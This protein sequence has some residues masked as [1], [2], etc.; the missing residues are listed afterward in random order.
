[1][2]TNDS[3]PDGDTLTV[4]S[5][6]S[7]NG[8]IVIE[9]DG[10][11]TYQPDPNFTGT[12][13]IVY[14]ISDGNGGT[15]TATVDVTVTAVNDAPETV[16]LPDLFDSN[17]EVISV[18]LGSAFSDVDDA[19]LTYTITGLPTGLTFDPA[20]GEVTGTTGATASSDVPDGEYTVTVTA[21]DAAGLNASTT[22]TW[23]ITNEPPRAIND[24][25]VGTEDTLINL[26]VLTNDVDPDGDP[27]T[28]IEI[29]SAVATNGTA[30]ILADGTIDFTPDPD[31]NGT[32]TVTYTIQD[33]NGKF[34]SAVA[35]I[36]IDAV[37]DAPDG[38]IL[39]DRD[40]EDG[41]VVSV[42][43]GA[44]FSDPEGDP[45]TF[46]TANLP[47]GLSIDMMT[48][49]ITGTIDPDASQVNG[50]VYQ[51]EVT[52]TD[53]GGE[54]TTQS[55]IWTI[56]NPGPTAN[57]DTASTTEDTPTAPIDVLTNDN[58]PDGDAL[59]VT[60]ASAPNGTVVINADGTLTYTPDV[61]FNGTD[62]I[63][64]EIS[65]GQ[66]GSSTSTVTVTVGAEMMIR[67]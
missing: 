27:M 12:D 56:T 61:N 55:F 43:F 67:L 7:D 47:A 20:T 39:P 46:T 4:I 23:T 44:L 50:G 66:G 51:V 45:L 22:F 17:N 57:S 1:M 38:T 33:A 52:A 53:D 6:D 49:E 37:N 2:L 35:T 28:P 13:T 54:A 58:D 21:T 8:T 5:A 41:D 64:Y 42:D 40:S 29:V 31:F 48:G 63:T 62:T 16:G 65:D 24:N 18:P 26:D 3:D 11:L 19:T 34:A 32:A 30:V 14:T 36:V 15:A 10:S 59:T 25:Y 60:T 9:A